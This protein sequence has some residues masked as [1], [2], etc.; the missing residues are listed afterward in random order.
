MA[1]PTLLKK[2]QKGNLKGKVSRAMRVTGP[3]MM[4]YGVFKIEFLYIHLCGHG[5][6]VLIDSSNLAAAAANPTTDMP[7]YA[8]K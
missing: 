3:R 6:T 5:L 1:K 4:R 7:E 8:T 2:E